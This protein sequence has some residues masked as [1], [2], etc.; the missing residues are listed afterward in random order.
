MTASAIA[1]RS[2]R[3]TPLET[4]DRRWPLAARML[5]EVFA[6]AAAA[7]L[8]LG[9]AALLVDGA[10]S[11]RA[12]TAPA[13]ACGAALAAFAIAS[14]LAL[15]LAP[16][17]ALCAAVAGWL[18]QRSPWP[19]QIPALLAGCAAFAIAWQAARPLERGALSAY[20]GI[21]TLAA[22]GVGL[23]TWLASA[24]P[25][26]QARV[27]ALVVGLWPA[28]ADVWLAPSMYVEFHDIAYLMVAAALLS[29]GADLKRKLATAAAPPL[30][31]C[32]LLLAC[33]CLLVLATADRW[34]VGWRVQS[35][36]NA[37]HTARLMRAAY[38]LSDLDGDGYSAVAWGTDC[39][40]GDAQRHPL[41]LDVPGGGDEN[42]NGA[43]AVAAAPPS[44]RGL[45][46]PAGVPHLPG[47]AIDLLVLVTIDTWRADALT[48]ELMPRLHAL[49]ERG[50]RFSRA[51]A[52]G[53]RTATSLA[54]VHRA[55]P[56][57]PWLARIL[58]QHGVLARA[59]VDG[60]LFPSER[61]GF[62]KFE[63]MK[64]AA[65]I[66]DR[67]IAHVRTPSA[68]PRLLWVHYSEPH[69][70]RRVRSDVPLPASPPQLTPDY[71]SQVAYVDRELARL[72]D[73]LRERDGLRRT[74]LV[75]TSDHGE[76]LGEHEIDGHGRSGFEPLIAIPAVLI[77]PGL[78]PMRYDGLVSHRD[79]APTVLG[80]YGLA[81]PAQEAERFGRSWLRLRDAPRAELHRFVVVHS[82]RFSSGRTTSV[83][84]LAL[85][86]PRYKL[87]VSFE[88][89]IA[90]LFD[91]V[92]DPAERT[93]FVMAEPQRSAALVRKAAMYADLEALPVPR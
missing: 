70:P 36:H 82:A 17:I 22:I 32:V 65:A 71:R 73:A 46:E 37:R 74:A 81:G 4:R 61:Y 21:V 34:A 76:G 5:R 52:S 30:A 58:D 16:A 51:Y 42:C 63:R 20:A 23:C 90:E 53:T 31:A 6:W 89:G 27:A 19:R 64:G 43:D 67:A 41:A 80:A 49:S 45:A 29:A 48:P 10:L 35:I 39:A 72:T 75:V 78:A 15:A 87:V 3:A 7:A 11:I 91:R 60:H 28:L 93:D 2:E 84:L 57:R 56:G 12:G 25:R 24:H 86:E 77:A 8:S 88:D 13:L 40:E 47:G 38:A 18:A 59:V 14:G 83:Q 9:S 33:G 69:A 92:R 85:V 54:R 79:I 50:V 62:A 44:A 68:G 55:S 66:T 1:A 26:S